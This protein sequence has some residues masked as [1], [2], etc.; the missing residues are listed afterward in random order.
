[1]RTRRNRA[2]I[3]NE[4]IYGNQQPI[5]HGHSFR[6]DFFYELGKYKNRVN[7]LYQRY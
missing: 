7:R 3:Y 1:M 6:H 2:R 4:I 5:E